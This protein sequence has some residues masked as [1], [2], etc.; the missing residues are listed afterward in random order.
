MKVGINMRKKIL[1][2]I[3]ALTMTAAVP[4]TAM[5]D[6]KVYQPGETFTVKDW[7]REDTFRI[8]IISPDDFIGLNQYTTEQFITAVK[9]GVARQF[10]DCDMYAIKGTG[11]TGAIFVDG[12]Q[13]TGDRT[14][15]EYLGAIHV[16]SDGTIADYYTEAGVA[17]GTLEHYAITTAAGRLDHCFLYQCQKDRVG[18]CLIIMPKTVNDIHT[19]FQ[20]LD[21]NNKWISMGVTF[22][23]GKP[24]TGGAVYLKGGANQTASAQP[25]TT[26]TWVSDASGWRVQNADGSYLISQWFQSNGLWYYLGTDGYMLTNTTTPDGYRVNGDGVWVQ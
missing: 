23:G 10:P 25:Q 24:N 17:I 22:F 26:Q 3:L 18:Y 11:G 8:D 19:E 4:M 7:Y 12:N 14:T 1:S 20:E 2:V 16:Y 6:Q 13:F 9:T 5:A 21:P 15:A